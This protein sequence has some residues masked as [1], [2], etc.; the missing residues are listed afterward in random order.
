L[1]QKSIQKLLT[2]VDTTYG[3]SKAYS[4]SSNKASEMLKSDGFYSA[5]RK[6]NVG[7]FDTKNW[8]N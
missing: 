3:F 8:K 4:I 1:K 2:E 6:T 5:G 7:G